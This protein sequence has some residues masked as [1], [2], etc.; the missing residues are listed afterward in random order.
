MKKKE[1]ID[2]VMIFLIMMFII[3][4]YCYVQL[5]ILHK[6]YINFFG[7]TFFRVVSGSMENTIQINDIVIV[8]LT[9]EIAEQD[10]ITYQSNNNFITHRVISINTNEVITQGDANN[11]PDEPVSKNDILGKV[12]FVI[13]VMI[14]IKVFTS[15]EVVGAI[16]VSIL[17]LWMVFHK[18]KGK[19]S[20]E[21]N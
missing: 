21:E 7:F 13:P 12:V 14:L 9:N 4:S 15:P 17:M 11:T 5:T 6:E 20:K 19:I 1:K 18:K 2:F 10:I 16:V 8:K 3:V